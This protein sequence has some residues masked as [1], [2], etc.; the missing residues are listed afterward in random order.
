[1]IKGEEKNNHPAAF[2]LSTAPFSNFM[3]SLI[4]QT[5]RGVKWEKEK[6]VH[7]TRDAAQSFNQQRIRK[8][9]Q[10][11]HLNPHCISS[12]D[13]DDDGSGA[14]ET[15]IIFCKQIITASWFQNKK[16]S[17]LFLDLIKLRLSTL[18]RRRRTF[19]KPNYLIAWSICIWSIE[20]KHSDWG[21]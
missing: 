15:E 9:K 1:M 2:D 16:R 21:K 5:A 4:N 14:S 6:T 18:Q 17:S 8:Q 19:P 3:S 7:L 13:A 20:S 12:T 10:I 11:L